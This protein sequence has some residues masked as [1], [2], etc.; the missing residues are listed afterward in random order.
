M[1]HKIKAIWAKRPGR[2]PAPEESLQEAIS[3]L[4]RITNETVAEHREE[5]LSSAR[6]FI[7][8]LQHSLRRVVSISAIIFVTLTVA[9]FAYCLVALY[10]LHN[11]STFMYR[12][13]QVIPFPVAKAGPHF[14]S[15]ESYLFELRHYMHYYQTQQ[16]VDFNDERGKQQLDAFR[17]V[18]LDLVVNEAYIKQ[19]AKERK[20][21]VSE[22]ELK[23]E[24][25]LLRSQ[26]R[27]GSNDEVF[28]DVLREFWGWSIN[29][30]K[31]ELRSQM[32][33][34]KVVSAMDTDTHVRAQN[35]IDQLNRGADFGELAKQ[36]SEDAGTK[37]NGGDYG[38]SIDKNNRDLPPQVIGELFKLQA[39][40]VSG[41]IETPIG[42]ELLKVR[43][44]E[45]N[46]VRASHIL[47]QFKPISTYVDP[48]KAKQKPRQF[49][50][51]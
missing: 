13:T 40:Q 38:F 25:N 11:T 21:S 35:V 51:P 15:Y 16:K 26:N 34:Q 42:L 39:G 8:P 31:R 7:Y 36:L 49:I 32:L 12:I 41:I 22:Q 17:K 37:G 30:F 18:A 19:L 50:T 6:K 2:K 9:F 45:G 24:I 33:A 20:I 4:P 28:E 5:V 10:K 46:T 44:V 47:L 23:D 3:N 14:V 27:L 43:E 48:L 29:D 1:K